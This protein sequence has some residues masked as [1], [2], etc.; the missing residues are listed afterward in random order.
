MLFF[1][2]DE[3]I[4]GTTMCALI[5]ILCSQIGQIGIGFLGK[6]IFHIS[7]VQKYRKKLILVQILKKKNVF[8]LNDQYSKSWNKINMYGFIGI[9]CKNKVYKDKDWRW[10]TQY[11]FVYNVFF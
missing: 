6:R 10:N 11:R 2:I 8:M 1:S 5:L 4:S 9:S 7:I 3:Y